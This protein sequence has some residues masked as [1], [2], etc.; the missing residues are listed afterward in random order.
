MSAVPLR[1]PRL[2]LRLLGKH[3][4]ELVCPRCGASGH[5]IVFGFGSLQPTVAMCRRCWKRMRRLDRALQ[6]ARRR[7]A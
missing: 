2:F 4:S 7:A 3:R 1:A 5:D 6:R